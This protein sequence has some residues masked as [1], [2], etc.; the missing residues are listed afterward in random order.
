MK[1]LLRGEIALGFFVATVFWIVV[2]G[3]ATSFNP[4]PNEKKACYQA[5][6][7]SGGNTEI[8]KT[9]WEKTTSD[10][11]AAFTL[12]L[13]FST[14]GLWVAT[15]L[16]YVAGERH[17]E[18]QLRAYVMI[19]TVDI[20]NVSLGG[21]PEA[22]LNIKNFGQTPATD[23]TCWATM[24]FSTF[25]LTGPLP[26]RRAILPQRPLAPTGTSIVRT[27]INRPLNAATVAA[28]AAG[29]HAIYVTG[30]I[31][32]RDAFD[33]PRETDFRLFCTRDMAADGTMAS[34][35]NGNRIT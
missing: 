28:I 33:K 23:L 4:G 11:V 30:E 1:T 22:T 31:R 19:D 15:L 20:E 5:A 27:G 8:C 24:G 7:K 10:P 2:L 34:Y 32:Y 3:W 16:I 12:V 14:I 6:A 35:E 13:A 29:S 21:N 17:S 18:R 9:F 26:T 25:P